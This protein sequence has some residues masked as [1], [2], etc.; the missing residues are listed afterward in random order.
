MDDTY[1][2]ITEKEKQMVATLDIFCKMRGAQ[3]PLLAAKIREFD[4]EIAGK[5]AKL[6]AIKEDLGSRLDGLTAVRADWAFSGDLRDMKETVTAFEDILRD[7]RDVKRRRATW[8]T[9]VRE[10]Q[11]FDEILKGTAAGIPTYC[12]PSLGDKVIA[13]AIIPDLRRGSQSQKS[14]LDTTPSNSTATADI[15]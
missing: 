4:E 15:P 11:K 8:V 5:E 7:I 14:I 6:F 1:G 10:I 13:R 9:R 3:Y 2:D 12:G